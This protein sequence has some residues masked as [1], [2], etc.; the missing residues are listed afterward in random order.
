MFGARRGR[1]GELTTWTA[2]LLPAAAEL[3]PHVEAVLARSAGEVDSGAAFADLFGPIMCRR[4]RYEVHPKTQQIT[5]RKQNC[6]TI[7]ECIS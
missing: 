7:L 2:G 3:R 1:L 6:K 5:N 4:R